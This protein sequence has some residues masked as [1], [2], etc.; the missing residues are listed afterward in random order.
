MSNMNFLIYGVLKR[1]GEDTTK[2]IG[3]IY[4]RFWDIYD[5]EKNLKK[6]LII[7]DF[8]LKKII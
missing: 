8:I 1:L 7:R 2:S 5:I 3:E 4:V 6:S